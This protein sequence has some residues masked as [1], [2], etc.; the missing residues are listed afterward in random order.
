MGY[1]RRQYD[2]KK[3]QRLRSDNLSK[4]YKASI[5]I[6][7]EKY[8]IL[9]G[10]GKKS[11]ISDDCYIKTRRQYYKLKGYH[12]RLANKTFRVKKQMDFYSK[13]VYD[14]DWTLY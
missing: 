14:L 6:K 3:L 1:F 4:P 11:I 13:K 8:G 7:N 2:K 5:Y 10:L 12:K 9:I